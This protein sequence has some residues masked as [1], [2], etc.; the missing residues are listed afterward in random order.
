MQNNGES[1]N[2]REQFNDFVQRNRKGIFFSLGALVVLLVGLVVFLYVKDYLQKKALAEV[3]VLNTR[4]TD[5]RANLKEEDSADDVQSLL[6]DL[7]SFVNSKFGL[8]EGRGWTV[9][10]QIHSEREEWQQ[11]EDAWRNAAKAAANSYL[12]PV[13]YFNA[14]AA[15]EEQGKTEQ[16]IELLEKSISSKFEFPAA[17]RAQFSIGRLNE[18]LGNIPE[19]VIAYRLVVS[20][21]PNL[22]GWTE[23]ANSRIVVLEEQ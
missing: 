20:K 2:A 8:A 17:A 1:T 11:A 4:F 16:A 23:L 3:E 10:A 14:A 15:A 6:V 7:D 12:A 5:M 9:I 18:Q 13:A 19:A 22:S 21:W